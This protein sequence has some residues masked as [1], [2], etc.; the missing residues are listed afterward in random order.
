MYPAEL[1]RSVHRGNPGDV[2]YYR[3]VCSGADTVLEL[4][5]GAGRI[6]HAVAADGVDVVGLEMDPALRALG[7]DGPASLLAGDMRSFSLGRTFDRILI[8]YNGLY[9]LTTDA[10]QLRCLEQVRAHLVP[11]GLLVFDGYNADPF[12]EEGADGGN[13]EDELGMVARA[14]AEGRQWRVYE[15]SRWEPR[16]QRITA[17]YV[18]VPEDGGSPVEATIV[19]RYLLSWQVGPL[20]ARAGLSLV[21]LQGGFDQSAHD[22][23]ESDLLIGIARLGS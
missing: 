16:A 3:R 8:P 7:A 13:D 20:L 18:H 23:D 2:D 9:C 19:Q 11:T 6:A 12:H 15:Q 21:A 22:P 4:G 5:C 17:R 14:R 10:D 1:Y